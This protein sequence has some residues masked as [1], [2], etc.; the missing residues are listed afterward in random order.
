VIPQ[1]RKVGIAL[2]VGFLAVF[3]QLNYIQ[4]FAA[5][6]IAS[7]PANFR[8]LLQE[9]AIRRGDILTLDGV[10]V[11]NSA[12]TRGRFKFERRYPEGDLYAHITG[13]YSIV[14][15]TSQIESSFNDQL[16][17]ESG[18]VSMQDIQDRFLEGGEQGDNVRLTIDSQLQRVARSA[19]GTQQGAV[20]AIDPNTGEIRAMWSNPSYD[21]N[22]L[23]VH[24]ADQERAFWDSL[25]P[26]SSTSPLISKA[27]ARS[28]APGSTFKVVTA[29]AALESG[30]YNP[31]SSFPDPVE[32]DLPQTDET[33]QNFS[34]TTCAGG[35]INLFDA[36][37]VSCDTTF[38]IIGM[39]IHDEIG[40]VSTALGFNEP[41]DTDIRTEAS[42]FPEIG[43]DNQP[44]RAFAGI[45][46]GDVSATPLQM[47]LVAATVANGG[48][49]PRPRFVREVL[50]ASGGIVERVETESLGE[51]FS[52]TTAS[53]LTQMMIAV[54]ESG[55]GTA[56]QM[57]GFQVAGKTGTAQTGVEGGAPH[58]WFICFAPADDPQ[59]AVAVLVENGGSVGSEATG[60]AVAAPIAK[61]LLEA[62]RRIRDW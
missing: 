44:L 34:K 37:R 5:E 2:L 46:Q 12:P 38:A 13:F 7:N 40:R 57:E 1:I 61:A 31:Q 52:T 36:L 43:D 14:F 18:V 6:E 35:R 24:E 11:A 32:L 50:D 55:T 41:I 21:P 3:L 15:G 60:G 42:V 49:V 51:A 29:A 48:D 28:F 16:L 20:V 19:L 47:A 62:D 23:A 30:E 10:R 56:A 25:E 27:S 9:Y 59:L 22:G 33:L 8:A 58:A 45:G 17:G 39:D 53:Q 54:V 4:I 26:Q